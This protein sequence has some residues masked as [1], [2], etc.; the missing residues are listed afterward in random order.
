[1]KRIGVLN[2]FNSNQNYGA[3]LQAAALQEVLKG[4]GHSSEHI[5]LVRADPDASLMRKY[6]K[7]IK[8]N[9]LG[10][11]FYSCIKTVYFQILGKS[12]FDQFRNKYI[13]S[14]TIRY[15]GMQDLEKNYFDYEIVVVGSDQV[16]RLKYI[17]ELAPAYF[18]SFLGSS[19]KK[20]SYAA[21]FGLDRWEA[22]KDSDLTKILKKYLQD[23]SAISV[24]EDSGVNIC[25][26]IFDV[27]AHHVLDPTLL[28]GRSFFEQI[29]KIKVPSV[30]S[31]KLVYYKLDKSDD[32]KDMVRFIE[33][34]YGFES[35]D[36]YHKTV[37][38]KKK[39]Y[40]PVE[41]WLGLIASSDLV[42]TDSYHCVCFSMLFNKDF[43]YFA[44]KDRGLSRVESLLHMFDVPKDRIVHNFNKEQL[45]SLIQLKIDYA[46]INRRLVVLQ[47]ESLRFL[48]SAID[49]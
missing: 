48:K 39:A 3:V 15:E 6:F 38:K 42:I 40:R 49:F 35:E 33:D 32:F 9:K 22:E 17:K 21:S 2:F 16:W 4:L 18:F 8:K 1:M 41:D 31:R 10:R 5:D 11:L 23:F 46:H 12:V 36:I 37:S 30:R 25:N 29:A 45:T 13:V 28:I 47:E 19:V 43:F 34:Q 44:N 26:D 7:K 27:E 14:S 24:R 20:I